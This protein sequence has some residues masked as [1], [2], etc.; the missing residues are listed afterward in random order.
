MGDTQV[1]PEGYYD[2]ESPN[3]WKLA[4]AKRG[5]TQQ[6]TR[7]WG[8]GDTYN[9]CTTC[10]QQVDV[11]S[12]GRHD[13]DAAL[14]IR[15][16]ARLKAALDAA[17]RPKGDAAEIRGAI[18]RLRDRY[19]EQATYVKGGVGDLYDDVAN[20]LEDILWLG[21]SPSPEDGARSGRA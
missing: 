5:H 8:P 15:E 18:K 17:E 21:A 2:P 11:A 20:D 1:K 13:C 16:N 4:A 19:R 14:L 3:Y 7:I 12:D 10:S 9:V 6:S